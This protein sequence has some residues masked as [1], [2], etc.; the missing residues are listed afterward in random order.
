MELEILLVEDSDADVFL[1]KKAITHWKNSQRI[2]ILRDGEEAID[3]LKAPS[4]K[5][6]LIVLD[7]NLPKK[8][9]FEILVEIKKKTDWTK[10]PVVV[11]TGSNRPEE[12][13]INFRQNSLFK[14]LP[15]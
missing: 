10:I 6:A 8:S 11:F 9:G 2:T 3:F 12:R 1:F 15:I 13:D 4:I 7:L 14:N 5:P